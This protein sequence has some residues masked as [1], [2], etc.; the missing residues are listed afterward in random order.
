MPLTRAP[1]AY[2][3]APQA[4]AQT[5]NH[6]FAIF[7]AP[8]KG[9]DA[10]RPLVSQDP[11]TGV[12]LD[13]W[14]CRKWGPELRGGYK[15]WTSNLGGGVR[16]V[17]PYRTP[18]GSAGTF[19]Q[20]LFVA[21][22]DGKVYNV[23]TATDEVTTP[24]AAV[25]ITGQNNPGNFSYINVTIAGVTYLAIVGAG[26][27]YWTFD[28]AGGWVNRTANITGANAAQF[29]FIMVWKNR[30]WFIRNDTTEAYFLP[31][32]S[33]QGAASKF[34]FGTLLTHG[35]ALAVL[36]SW[37]LD[38]GNGIDDKFVVIATE[39]DVLVYEGTD[40]ISASTFAKVGTWFIGQ[41]PSGR[42]FVANEGGDLS[43][44]TEQGVEYISKI[45]QGRGLLNPESVVDAPSFR[46]NHIIGQQVKATRGQEFWSLLYHPGEEAMLVGTPTATSSE[47]LQFAYSVLGTA[48]STF[49]NMPMRAA[50]LFEGDLYFGDDGG[51]VF[52]AFQATTDGELSDGTAGADI[53]GTVQTAYVTDPDNPMLLKR[54][55]LIQAMFQSSS[56]PSV[57]AQINTEWS[58]AGTAGSPSFS[59]PKGSLWGIAL[60]GISVWSEAE[61]A[62]MS[63]QG[64][65]GLGVYLSLNM[66]VAGLPGTV[67]TSWKLIY[68]PGGVM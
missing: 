9:L 32:D 63:W 41:T 50:D 14:W 61:Q 5:Q 42:R 3:R 28:H 6:K 27:G 21:C 31:V 62:Y 46:F 40:P 60:W 54:P 38:A 2:R 10:S 51:H 17:M 30:I 36:A 67:F 66:K 37:T 33:I 59:A 55:Q 25:T 34:D 26:G 15:R 43:I 24:A 11:L 45:T 19:A 57:S 29:D 35:G 58:K 13:N 48:W 64:V 52:L 18:P 47:A 4:A 12:I 65:S 7:P 16:S 20:K 49:T 39:G 68:E 22:D 1:R 44:I 56:P 8:N 53:V 23:T